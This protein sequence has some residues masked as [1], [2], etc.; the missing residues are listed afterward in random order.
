M[1]GSRRRYA[2]SP[3][4]TRRR[5]SM[6]RISSSQSMMFAARPIISTTSDRRH[7]TPSS[8]RLVRDSTHMRSQGGCVTESIRAPTRCLRMSMQNIG[9][10]SGFS[11][12]SSVK[13]ILAPE[14]A[15]DMSSRRAPRRVYTE[16]SSE[17]RVGCCT[18]SMRA[19][20]SAAPSSAVSPVRKT[21]SN[22]IYFPP[23]Q[24]PSA[25]SIAAKS[26]R[27]RSRSPAR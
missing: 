21:A 11:Y 1:P 3:K 19:P 22:G 23:Y 27:I 9:G 10:L 6:M 7:S 8:S 2:S 15:A 20:E 18:L 13:C 17:S 12:F 25:A 5:Q 16:R 24:N 4:S 26:S 14:P